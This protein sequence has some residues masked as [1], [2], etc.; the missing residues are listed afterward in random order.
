RLMSF[1]ISIYEDLNLHINTSGSFKSEDLNAIFASLQ[2]CILTALI[3]LS[4][5]STPLNDRGIY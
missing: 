3:S 2:T 4:S 1:N 5:I